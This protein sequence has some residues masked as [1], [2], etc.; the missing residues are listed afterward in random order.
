MAN[1]G[2]I[3]TGQIPRALQLGV[4]KFIQHYEHDYPI[5][6]DELFTKVKAEKGFYEA[7]QLAGM[8]LASRKNEGDAITYDS[9]DQDW[10]YRWPVHVYEKSARITMEM[11]QD[12]LYQ[13]MLPMLAKE[14]VKAL[15]HNRDTQMALILNRAFNASFTG[16]DASTLCS[17]S[18][19]I[20]AGGTSSNRL[21]PDLDLSEDAV[22][23]TVILIDKFLNPD[24][25][26]SEY[27]SKYLA[28]PVDLK[29]EACRILKSKYQTNSANNDVNALFHRGD[30]EDYVVWK[31]LSDTD[32]FFITTDADNSLMV[33][34]RKGIETRMF[35]D[36]FTYDVVVTAYERFRALFADWRGIAGTQGA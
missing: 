10:V 36:P 12:N 6:G 15:K 1:S 25:L 2:R 17:T 26:K 33:A 4:D 30:I 35:N 8:G 13:D 18:H 27:K 22:E 28:V 20:Q 31:R 3:T 16:P 21:S 7:V 32:A 5:I 34:E 24:G 29:Y 23:Q 11:I 9:I 19:A 14:Q